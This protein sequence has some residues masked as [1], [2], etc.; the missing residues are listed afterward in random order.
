LGVERMSQALRLDQVS[1]RLL[2]VD[3]LVE[4]VVAN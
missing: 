1:V 2:G 3:V 4:G